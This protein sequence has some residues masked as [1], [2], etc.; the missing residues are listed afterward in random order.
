MDMLKLRGGYTR[1]EWALPHL[2]HVLIRGGED[3]GTRLHEDRGRDWSY[4]STSQG[5]PEAPRSWQ[6][7]GRPLPWGLRREQRP[8]GT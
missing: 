5:A 6:R 3:K 1:L 4:V 2:T 7:K 8:A